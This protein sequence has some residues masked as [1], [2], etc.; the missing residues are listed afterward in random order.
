MAGDVNK[1]L[2]ARGQNAAFGRPDSP[3]RRQSRRFRFLRLFFCRWKRDGVLSSGAWSPNYRN[4]RSV[5][6]LDQPLARTNCFNMF[7]A[8]SASK[9]NIRGELLANN[10]RDE[11]FRV[12]EVHVELN[13]AGRW[14]WAIARIA[15]D[16]SR[17]PI[18][19]RARRQCFSPNEIRASSRI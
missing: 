19:L 2:R 5:I 12:A 18:N 13:V 11:F 7:V 8:I 9:K 4:D 3:R 14:D 17:H 6:H 15:Q 16:S 10:K 1:R